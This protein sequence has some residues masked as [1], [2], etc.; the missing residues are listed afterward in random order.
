MHLTASLTALTLPELPAGTASVDVYFDDARVWS[1]DVRE[2]ANGASTSQPV[3]GGE[4]EWPAALLP[5]LV[6]SARV[7]LTD[8]ASGAELAGAETQFTKA[9]QRT[10]VIDASGATLVINKWGRLGVALEVMGDEVQT[11]IVQR[12]AELVDFLAARGLRPFVVGGTLLGAVRSQSLLPHDDDADIAYLSTHTDPVEVAAEAF[13]LGHAIAA[14]GYEVRRHSAAHLQLMFRDEAGALQ[15]YIDVFTA[16]FTADGCVNQPF[17]VRDATRV[18]QMLPFGTVRIND[19]D[20]PAPADTEHWLTINYDKNWRTPIPGYQLVTPDATRRRFNNWFGAF[21]L[22][23]EF[24]DEHFSGD[25][26]AEAREAEWAAGRWWLE[27]GDAHAPTLI[28]L[29]SGAGTLTRAFAAQRPSRRVIGADFCEI[30]LAQ[31]SNWG[32]QHDPDHH[33]PPE[34][35]HANLYRVTALALPH[36]VGVVGAFDLVANHLLEQLG[37]LGREQVWRLARMAL[38]TG[39]SARFT[40]HEKH[41]VDVTFEDP[42]GWHLSRAQLETEA[43][44]FGLALTFRSLGGSREATGT[45]VSL[46]QPTAPYSPLPERLPMTSPARHRIKSRLRRLF[47]PS[48]SGIA[49]ELQHERDRVTALEHE[50]DELRRDSLRIAELTDVLEQRLTPAPGAEAPDALK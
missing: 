21:N 29:G 13:R 25:P 43:Q 45:T 31:A 47:S 15:H 17:H 32:E 27:T 41:A 26:L 49:D 23:R 11:R 12:A 2:R 18:D 16:F 28:E 9:P 10:R 8:S 40:F 46:A 35:A 1:I 50:I 6:G 38:A 42:T 48:V 7:S 30:A 4:V 19:T 14:A 20:F 33:T 24:W 36:D 22:H 34:Y 3:P 39:G 5:Y 44:R 37:H